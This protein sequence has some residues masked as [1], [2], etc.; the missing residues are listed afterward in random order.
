M[1][2]MD[3]KWQVAMILMR[4]K[5]F[6]NRTSKK[7]QFDTRGPVGFDKTK[8]EGFNC[9]K[10]GHFARDCRAKWN[11]ESRRKD[12]N[13]MPS[14]PDVEIDYSKFTY[15]LKQTSVDESGSKPVEY[16]S[17]ESD[18]SVETT[19]SMLAPI[20]N[21]PKIV[22]E[23]KVWTDAPIIEDFSHLIRDCDFHE[24][25]M[26]KQAAL[27]K[28]K[29][30]GKIP[31]N[32]AR[33][34]FS[35]QAALTSTASKVN[36]AIPFV[37]ETRPTRWNKSYL[38]DYQ[39]FKGGSIAFGGINGRITGKG[40]IKA[41]KLDFKDVYYVEELKHYNLFS[42]SQMCDKKNKILFTDTDCLV[43]SLDFQL[44]DENQLLLK[45]PR[46]HNMYSFNLKNI[47]P[48]GDLSCLFIKALIDE[49]N[50]WHKRAHSKLRQFS[51][52]YFLKSKDETTPILKDFIRKAEN[53]FNH[54]V[55]TIR[56]D[57][58]TEFKNSELTELCGLKRI[59][60]EYSNARTPQQNRVAE[61]KNMTLIE[62][63]RTML[64]DLFLPTTFW[65]EAVKTACYV[66]NR[67][68]V[69]KPQN[70]T[71][72]QLLT[73]RQPI[74][75]Y[76]RP[77]GCH[78][79]ILNT[80]D[81]LGKF[82]RK[83]DSRFLVGYSLNSKDFRIYNLKTK[84]VEENL[85]VN[86]LENKLNVVGKGH[87]WMFGLDY[88]TNS[89]NYEPVSLENQANKSASPKEANHSA[90]TEAT[91]VQDA[92]SEEIDIY[93]EHFVLPL[94]SAYSTSVK[95]SGTKTEKTT[96]VKTSEKPSSQVEQIFQEE[97]EKLKRQEKEANDAVWKE[98]TNETQ[99]V[100]TNSTN[101]MN[102]VSAL[103]SA[104]GPS[105][106]LKDVE[107][108]Y[109]DDLSMPHLEDIYASLSAGIFTDS[110]YDDEALEDESWVDAMQ[111]ELVQFQIQ[112]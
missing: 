24:K 86:F 17:S 32:A 31:V 45:I 78:V 111:E 59:K 108:S 102:V 42:V 57:N 83:S 53:Q 43:L 77:F 73:G 64:V 109:P 112:K 96:D 91:D 19:T 25:R 29:E 80:I 5:K 72:C 47:N 66:L 21:A 103:V 75:S 41:G 27:T 98:A 89:M 14:G 97:L 49:S 23:P 94:W 60:R 106:A 26:A 46:Q 69:T 11:Q 8:V 36:T 18:S 38:A 34:N 15:G 95:S 74:I 7:L 110:S 56:S 85:H 79:T 68:L 33:Q 62:A 71:P 39:E 55:K 40:N 58:G 99:D 100:N 52:V 4:I 10:I 76:I 70:K 54:K 63:A 6:H 13:Y 90:G 16:A 105:R 3:I 9:H 1:E 101:L 87:A 20:D 44:P 88:L 92:N 50:K 82:D 61:R 37:N 22:C 30:K 107:A 67:V 65:A 93:D 2:E 48:S 81:Q 84:I 35:R 104:F 51:W 28:N 12:G